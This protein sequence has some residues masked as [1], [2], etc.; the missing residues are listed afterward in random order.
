MS[1]HLA[2]RTMSSEKFKHGKPEEENV[3]AGENN[4]SQWKTLVDCD[5]FPIKER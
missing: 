3:H 2:I 4:A 5:F 1:G